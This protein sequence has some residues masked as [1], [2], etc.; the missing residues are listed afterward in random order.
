MLVRVGARPLCVVL[1]ALLLASLT[2]SAVLR[3]QDRGMVTGSVT[4]AQGLAL[5]GAT[6][7]LRTTGRVFVASRVTDRTGGFA[8]D[9]VPAG[10][11]LLAAIL[12][13]FSMHEERL[14]AGP[15]VV[16]VA[17]TLD[18][19]SFSQEVSVTAL[20]PELA[21]ELVTPASEI[22][23]RVVQDLARSLRSHAGVTAV[24]RGSINLDPSVRGLYA[25]QI[26]VF[27][28]GT[29][30]FAAGPARM[31]SALSHIS[32]HAL[33]SLRV[34]RGPYALTWGAGTLSAIQAETFKPAFGAGDL[35]LRGRAGY[36]YG[37]N[38][39]ANDGFA[40]L[41]GSSDR[42]R[43]TFQHN[44]RMG[45]DYTDGNG[46]TV[47]GDYESFD[48]RWDLGARLGRE[49]LLEYSGGFQRQNDID[50]PG[51]LLDA[52]FF[53]TQSHAVEFSHTPAAGVLTGIVGRAYVNLK[54][55]LMNNE[56]KPTALR[57][58]N[59]TPPFPI[60]VDLPASADTAGGRFHA[61]LETGPLRYKLGFDA[62]RLR[63]NATQTVS[64]RETGD[65]HHDRHPVWPHATLTNAGG[66]AQVLVDRG[67]STIGATVRVD[68]EQARV[69]QVTSF[70]ADNAIPAYALHGVHGHF[71]CVTAQCM[72][73]QDHAAGHAMQG[74]G[75]A[76]DQAMH[77]EG[78][79]GEDGHGVAMLV[80]GERFAQVNTSVS[81]AANASLR[82]T[83]NWLLT[84]G[85]G[86]AVRS[87]SALER[88]ADRFPAV[89]F[90]TAAE[91]VGNPHLVPE[92]S[93]ELNAGTTLRAAEAAVTLDVFL[94]NVDDY[95][96]VAPDPNLA[97]RLP[98]SPDQIFRYVQADAARFAGFDLT[99]IS[100]AGPWI[101]LRGGWSYVR[102]DD[103]LFGEPLF[104]VPPFEQQYALD[105]HNPARTRWLE[106]LV[107][108]TAAQERV[109]ATRFEVPTEG[110]TTIG[111]DGRCAD[112]RRTDLAGR[113][114][115]PDRPVLRQPSELV[116]SVHPPADCRAR[117]E[118]LHRGGSRF[119]R[120]PGGTRGYDWCRFR[121]HG[122]VKRRTT[123]LKMRT[124][125][126][127]FALVVAAVAVAS[128]HM[129]VQKTMPEAD[130]VLSA[131]P[132]QIQIWF[133]QSPDPAIS[134]LILEGANG[135]VA[136]GD[137]EVQ[138]DR[139]LMAMLPSELDA[140]TYTVKW[141]TAGDDGH[142]QRGDFAFTVRAAD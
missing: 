98:I 26:G 132:H 119:L 4:D 46:D 34:V 30:T 136:I 93:V 51:R 139:S 123:M 120:R 59:R 106:V 72:T 80:S 90:Q 140:G 85:A 73:P 110:W 141:R 115:E 37:S 67:R 133:T 33:Q 97:K 49:T 35:Q 138:D 68:R 124:A 3:A 6:I 129:A 74:H 24:R 36:N 102:A 27:V 18:V 20:M 29:R 28:D 55:H 16:D 83:D 10:D 76:H 58:H 112:E 87:P 22:E 1:Q 21:T 23:R 39:G 104:G 60:R 52:T 117:P 11:Y 62:Y 78:M 5:P 66:Y 99:A 107:T 48:T 105:V 131:S 17:I 57:N 92:K 79:H 71:H 118:R 103:L 31:D 122:V 40:S 135:E 101:D 64:D 88:Y 50:Y 81:A 108:S 89:K 8:L 42:L 25:E 95:I 116:Q 19:G 15:G 134:R 63:Q 127:C 94:R 82:L 77:D 41:Y 32:P 14:M 121:G 128:A 111:P 53:E 96:T 44:T 75:T 109:A 137:I 61:A 142:T 12:L 100:A 126:W 84:L 65:V 54:D 56:N 125:G 47:Q 45:A 7:V 70:F 130:E 114:A 9:G 86:R 2:G 13:G 43:F 69:G 38:G 91:F 113:R